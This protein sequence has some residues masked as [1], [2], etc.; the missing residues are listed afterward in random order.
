MFENSNETECLCHLYSGVILL[1]GLCNQTFINHFHL[2]QVER[3]VPRR[4]LEG[5]VDSIVL[6]GIDMTYI[7]GL[8]IVT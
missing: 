6:F 5:T 7:L 8:V 2:I 4:I 3:H 1:L